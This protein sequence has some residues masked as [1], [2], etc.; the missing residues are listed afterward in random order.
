M[1]TKKIQKLFRELAEEGKKSFD[2][3]ENSTSEN[4][5][6]VGLTLSAISSS[7]KNIAR[8]AYAFFEDGNNNVMCSLLNWV[9]NLYEYKH[10]SDLDNIKWIFSHA[11]E[12]VVNVKRNDSTGEWDKKKFVA[13]II[14]E[15]VE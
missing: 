9:F 14:F 4:F 12:Y 10:I 15:E 6:A 1:N 11:G 5:Q 13:R 8:L 3:L 2:N 7:S